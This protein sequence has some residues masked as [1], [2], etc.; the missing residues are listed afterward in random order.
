MFA[1]VPVLVYRKLFQIEA[2]PRCFANL[3]LRGSLHKHT[4][5]AIPRH[6]PPSALEAH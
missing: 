5:D 4:L 6:V 2:A 3:E 1:K